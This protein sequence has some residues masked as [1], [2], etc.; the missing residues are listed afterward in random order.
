MREA[1]EGAQTQ[2][3]LMLYLW[4][5]D[6][7][8]QAEKVVCRLKHNRLRTTLLTHT[9]S[10]FNE[11]LLVCCIIAGELLVL[12]VAAERALEQGVERPSA[13]DGIPTSKVEQGL[14][15][16]KKDLPW[17]QELARARFSPFSVTTEAVVRVHSLFVN[18]YRYL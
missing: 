16:E 15:L 13:G 4:G 10:P 7:I 1:V 12:R 14:F 17:Q 9:C 2:P 18:V 8:H 11:L 3:N 5:R 6:A